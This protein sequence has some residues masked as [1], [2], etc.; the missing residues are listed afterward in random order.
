MLPSRRTCKLRNKS[1]SG[2]YLHR[3]LVY[4]SMVSLA[5]LEQHSVF[6]VFLAFI[7]VIFWA[8]SWHVFDEFVIYVNRHYN[9]SKL[10]IYLYSLLF[11]FAFFAVYPKLLERL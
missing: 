4:S 1:L 2:A 11:V 9:I 3:F 5:R 6:I 10:N 8:S 7:L